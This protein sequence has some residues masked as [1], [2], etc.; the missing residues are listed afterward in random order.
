[1]RREDVELDRPRRR[2]GVEQVDRALEH[3]GRAGDGVQDLAVLAR[4]VEQVG[5]DGRYTSSN[6]SAA[7]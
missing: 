5:D 2:L 3:A 1:M 7:S 4:R 6:V